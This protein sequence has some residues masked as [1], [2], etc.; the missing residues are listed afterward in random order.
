MIRIKICPAEPDT[1]PAVDYNPAG[2][3]VAPACLRASAAAI[4][5]LAGEIW[6]EHYTPLIGAAQVEY[7]L[8]KY[9]SAE[10]IYADITENGFTYF[11][12][13][14]DNPGD[15]IIGYCGIVPKGDYLLL[16]KLYVLRAFRGLGAAR[17]MFDE[18]AAYC[19]RVY[20]LD[21]I[22]LT[23]NKHNDGSI[24]VYKKFGFTVVD[25]V[26]TDIGSGFYMDDYIMECSCF[27]HLS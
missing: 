14:T 20:A 7:M 2:P 24:A 8:A 15:G 9:Q 26:K 10:Q 22:R 6:R 4:A 1:G 25:S 23:V 17:R 19:K 18:A 27:N 11:T 21:K 12:A 3:D 16:S 13:E 5:G